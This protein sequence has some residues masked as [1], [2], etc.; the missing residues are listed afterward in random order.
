[1]RNSFFGGIVSIFLGG[2]I[3]PWCAP[4]ANTAMYS[5]QM[6]KDTLNEYINAVASPICDIELKIEGP[7]R[8]ARFDWEEIIVVVQN[9]NRPP[10]LTPIGNKKVKAGDTVTVVLAATD[11]DG[12][13]LSYSVRNLPTHAEFV[14]GTKTFVWTPTQE[15]V[16][17]HRVRFIVTDNGE[18]F[19]LDFEEIVITVTPASLPPIF[20]PV[21]PT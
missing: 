16:G 21:G 11:P 1:M 13:P 18:P 17:I 4:E 15:Q 19:K 14:V 2:I 12:D 5:S 7:S 9:E 8:H 3:L 10:V 20:L 6:A